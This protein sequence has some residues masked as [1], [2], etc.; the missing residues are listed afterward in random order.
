MRILALDTATAATSVAVLS[1]DRVVES[2]VVEGRRHAE[3][4]APL[5][6]NVLAEAGVTPG[7]LDLIA[8]GVG[9][10]PF[11]GL[12]V[13][14]TTA[15]AMGAA[16]DIPVVGACSLDVIARVAVREHPVPVTVLTRARRVELCWATYDDTGVRTG[17]PLIRR[18]PVAVFGRCVGDAGPVDA[19]M[20]PRAA[21]L[22]GLVLQRLE[23]GEPLP[24]DVTL[25][26]EDA[27]QSGAATA[28]VLA[29]RMLAG[30]VLLPPRPVY[31]RRPDAVAPAVGGMP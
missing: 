12:R 18:E 19:V 25:P 8:C 28:D 11:T 17:G 16:C 23:A 1:D 22:A 5:I 14:I 3:V 15:V 13:G 6:A 9:P 20:Y 10:G 31:L 24:A 30:V 2:D 27:I 26:E 7:D 4:I 21:D 29:S